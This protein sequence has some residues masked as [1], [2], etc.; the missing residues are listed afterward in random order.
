MD[1]IL[2]I[3]LYVV[4]KRPGKAFMAFNLALMIFWT[5]AAV[6]GAVGSFKYI[7]QDSINY[8]VRCPASMTLS[9]A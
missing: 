2:P 6:L 8:S 9:C 1:F 7:I 4:C 3:L 5:L